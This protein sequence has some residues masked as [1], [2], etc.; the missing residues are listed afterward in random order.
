MTGSLLNTALLHANGGDACLPLTAALTALSPISLVEMDRHAALRDRTDT[1]FALTP[2]QVESALV[3]LAS[4]YWVL[5]VDSRRQNAYQTLY[6][7]TPRLG[8]YQ[9]QHNDRRRVYKVRSRRY[10]DTGLAFIEVKYKL[11]P[12]HTTKHRLTTDGQLTELTAVAYAWLASYMPPIRPLTPTLWNDYTR[13]TLVSRHGPERVT[14]D[15]GLCFERPSGERQALTGVVLA[16][17]KQA[18]PDRHSPFRQL[19]RQWGVRRSGF[20]KYCLGISLLYPAV[21]HNNFNSKLRRLAGVA[22]GGPC[23]AH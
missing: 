2:T 10:V 20:S 1:K 16:E 18:R 23:A 12:D 8:L 13:I 22:G 5:E 4:D 21:K 15:G 14:L 11:G 3:A 7:D 6:F 17:V 9:A 19:M